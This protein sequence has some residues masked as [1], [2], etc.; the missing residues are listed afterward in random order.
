M[1][2]VASITYEIIYITMQEHHL[3]I[4]GA[5]W[6]STFLIPL[7][8]ARRLSFAATTR[9]GREVAGEK[10]IKWSFNPEGNSSTLAKDKNQFSKLPFAKHVLITF[11][12]KD[13]GQSKLL[14]EG[15]KHVYSGKEVRF[16]Q[17]GSTGIWQCLQP[18][19]WTTRHSPYTKDNPRAIAEDELLSLDGCVLNLAGLWGGERQPKNFAGRVAKTKEDVK[20]KTSLHMIHGQDVARVVLAVC[21]KWEKVGERQRWMVTD[22][23]VYDWWALFAGWAREAKVDDNSVKDKDEEP[24]SLAK[25]VFELMEERDVRALPRSMESLGRCYDVRELWKALGIAPLRAR[26]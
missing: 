24:S 11:P 16:I 25:W 21:E 22:G 2:D 1:V 10:T 26:I 7:L 6:S 5:G 8:R 17:L 4:L 9:D 15:Y 3:L 13:R 12:L 23:F 19:L 18:S 14:V 20:G